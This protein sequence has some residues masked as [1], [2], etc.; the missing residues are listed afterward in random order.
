[1]DDNHV[2]NFVSRRSDFEH[3]RRRLETLLGDHF[4]PMPEFCPPSFMTRYTRFP[5][6]ATMLGAS[7]LP[8]AADGEPDKLE[9]SY[10]DRW[11]QFVSQNS[12][13]AN[14]KEMEDRAAARWVS[15]QLTGS[16]EIPKGLPQ[17]VQS[18]LQPNKQE[19]SNAP[20][21]RQASSGIEN[22]D[23]IDFYDV[24]AVEF[25]A[26]K[27]IDFEPTAADN[28]LADLVQEIVD[29]MIEQKWEGKP[30]NPGAFGT[31]L[32]KRVSARLKGKDG[33]LVNV[34]V[35]NGTNRIVD[36][37][38]IE[39]SSIAGHTQVDLIRVET[40]YSPKLGEVLD[41][42]KIEEVYDVKSQPGGSLD[43]K[44]LSRLV[45]VK[46]GWPKEPVPDSY[47]QVKT[48]LSPKRW[49]PAKGWHDNPRFSARL[50]LW[51]LLLEHLDTLLLLSAAALS[52]KA[53][54]EGANE[55]KGF[56]EVVEMAADI[57]RREQKLANPDDIAD[58]K[59]EWVSG[60]LKRYLAQFVPDETA[61]D[62]AI[63]AS[64]YKIIAEMFPS[65]G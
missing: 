19:D 22:A 24:R 2:N 62:A 41:I 64:E 33:W 46:T 11:D 40:R 32:H 17:Q 14:W 60:P 65:N 63:R 29:K 4:V 47:G 50:K 27:Q 23:A 30:D 36:I 54:I 1:M 25:V 53:M 26:G 28:Q 43:S 37:G 35:E 52:A 42:S 31:E 51:Q 55:D 48:V 39:G 58:R 8:F 15:D 10:R 57:R 59:R 34:T 56:R 6:I 18:K 44:Q 5:D 9:G 49:T 38:S 7:R 16:G 3:I 45:A 20:T 21:E 13:F 61:L 12:Q